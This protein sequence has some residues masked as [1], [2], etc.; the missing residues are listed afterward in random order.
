MSRSMPSAWWAMR[1]ALA[2]LACILLAV[3]AAALLLI[4]DHVLLAVLP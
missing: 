2:A 4:P 1:D 3:L